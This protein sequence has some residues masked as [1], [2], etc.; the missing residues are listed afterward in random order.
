MGVVVN[1]AP[2]PIV[3]LGVR[4]KEI[5]EFGIGFPTWRHCS[6]TAVTTWYLSW[7]RDMS[8]EGREGKVKARKPS[9]LDR[10]I[11]GIR[12]AVWR[13]DRDTLGS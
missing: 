9:E 13:T 12:E 1:R 8:Y 4:I 6:V 3:S 2:E 5:T 7:Q 10:L 11:P